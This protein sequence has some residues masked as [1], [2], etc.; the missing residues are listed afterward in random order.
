M[1]KN[2]ILLKEN[3]PCNNYLYVSILIAR[4][5]FW[6]SMSGFWNL[7]IACHTAIAAT[8]IGVQPLIIFIKFYAFSCLCVCHAWGIGDYVIESKILTS[9]LRFF[10]FIPYSR[11]SCSFPS[12]PSF[13]SD[14]GA[15]KSLTT[16]ATEP[17]TQVD[18]SVVLGS[19]SKPQF[20]RWKMRKNL[21][22]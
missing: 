17:D 5:T 7:C 22:R 16:D 20:E 4:G 12:S 8:D 14:L 18:V 1:F 21:W 6:I 13:S 2:C 19:E 9:L 10:L 11:I 15:W 3:F